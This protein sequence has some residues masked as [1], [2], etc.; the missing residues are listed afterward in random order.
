MIL[1]EGDNFDKELAIVEA[2]FNKIKELDHP[3]II[4]HIKLIPPE[5][6]N[7][8]KKTVSFGMVLELPDMMDPENRDLFTATDLRQALTKEEFEVTKNRLQSY[9]I[10][11]L[12]AF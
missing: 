2:E 4:K 11:T 5:V 10:Q 6:E 3:K 7:I 9:I 12:H 1:S 8:F